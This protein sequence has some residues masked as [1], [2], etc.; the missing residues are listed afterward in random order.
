MIMDTECEGLRIRRKLPR[1][2]PGQSPGRKRICGILQGH[3]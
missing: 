1:Q 2:G 3:E